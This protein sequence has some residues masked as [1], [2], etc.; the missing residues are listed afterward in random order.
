[1]KIYKI[2]I[3][4]CS[5]IFLLILFSCAGSSNPLGWGN[6]PEEYSQ[7]KS[8][9]AD[10]TMNASVVFDIGAMVIY[11]KN[12]QMT[13][14]R[15]VRIQ[16]YNDGGKEYAN[17]RIPFWNNEK[18]T[19]IKAHTILPNGEKTKL[20]KK[21]IFEEGEKKS[22]RYK[23]FA[24]PG[25]TD[26]CIIEYKYTLHSGNIFH[27]K[28][29]YF[30]SEIPTE[31]SRITFQ[32]PLQLKYNFYLSNSPI[33]DYKPEEGFTPGEERKYV[34]KCEFNNL[35]PIP[36][37]P[38]MTAPQDYMTRLNFELKKIKIYSYKKKFITD[39]VDI[40]K[41]TEKG[42]NPFTKGTNKH[43]KN[44]SEHILDNEMQFTDQVTKLYQF[45]RDSIESGIYKGYLSSKIGT[46][47]EI[48]KKRRGSKIEKN[49]LLIGL[50]NSQRI[51]AYPVLI[52]TR[53]HGRFSLSHPR[54]DVFNHLIT[55]VDYG[56]QSFLLDPSD[57]YSPVELLPSQDYSFYG[58][59]L[60]E[61]K[62][63]F[64]EIGIPKVSGDSWAET[65]HAEIDNDGTLYAESEIGFKRFLNVHFRKEYDQSEDENDFI[66]NY[67]VDKMKNVEIDSFFIDL[68]D[69]VESEMK[70][71]LR[72]TIDGFAEVSGNKMYISPA[73]L[74]KHTVNI[75]KL[76]N[77]T[78]PIDYHYPI[79][80]EE[81][82]V[83]TFPSG[84]EVIDLPTKTIPDF[85]GHAF[86]KK[87]FTDGNKLHYTRKFSVHN[88][89]YSPSEY[90]QLK[91][92][93]GDIVQ[94]DKNII[95]VAKK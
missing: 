50:L 53:D 90:P 70:I 38:F 75:F 15:H 69:N 16:I 74:H 71:F 91:S 21:D 26:H 23:V 72:Y 29:W 60:N 4:I 14:S 82:I 61:N 95:T 65:S 19:G 87:Y 28:P 76:E 10:T 45:V 52:S 92:Y 20:S 78:Y 66:E 46:P 84:Y 85:R 43:L 40:Q 51:N 73:L 83:Y 89:Y 44:L 56:S 12:T 80:Y 39:W 57:R 64:L 62:P 32:I 9:P 11:L 81:K 25:V 2:F 17:I 5:S 86:E 88:T 33:I 49:L 1:M 34:A 8:F 54:L 79:S 68:G 3:F 63:E 55:F 59:W 37:E 27:L 94:S 24:I 18:V 42:Y 31:Y 58:L 47:K 36:D 22:L 6:I 77:R 13:L 30:Q 48:I 35:P 67:I 41:R 93:Y 7:R